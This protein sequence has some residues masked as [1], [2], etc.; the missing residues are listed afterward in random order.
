MFSSRTK[1]RLVAGFWIV[2][3]VSVAL[4]AVLADRRGGE[5]DSPPPSPTEEQAQTADEAIAEYTKWL[6]IVTAVLAGGALLQLYFLNSADETARLT[7]EAAKS[8]ADLALKTNRAFV[9]PNGP[10]YLSHHDPLSGTYWWSIHPGWENS[11]NTPTK[12]VYLMS[13]RW[14]DVT[15]IPTDY[16]FPSIGSPTPTFIGPKASV[17]GKAISIDATDL[18]DVRDGKKYLYVWGWA[19]YRDIFGTRLHVTK[20]CYRVIFLGNPHQHFSAGGIEMQFHHHSTHNC[21]D[22]GCPDYAQEN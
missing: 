3:F 2:L 16:N 22:E 21:A 4:S 17:S 8:S 6:V 19:R 14:L 18:A 1:E 13:G 11:G 7:A 20:Y 15:D 9:F 12:E 10:A 5:S